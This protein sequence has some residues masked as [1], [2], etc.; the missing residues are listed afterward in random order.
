MFNAIQLF[1][2]RKTTV[3]APKKLYAQT[4][5]VVNHASAFMDPWVIAELQRP[6][7]F[8]LTRGDVFKPLIKPFAWS[9]HMIPIFRTKENGADSS[10]KNE[11][12]FKEV[13]RLLRKRKSILI[14]GEGYTDDIFIRSLKPIKKGPARI[15]FGAM[16]T[17]NW[18]MD[19]KIQCSGINYADPNEF[20]SEVLVA[21]SEPILVK[22]YQKDYIENPSLAINE[23]TKEISSKLQDQLTYLENA[24]LTPFHNQIQSLTK[25][26]IAHQNS[27]TRVALKTRWE[28][29]KK[30][31][32]FLNKH[33]NENE[34]DWKNLKQ[35]H[36]NYSDLLVKEDMKDNWIKKYNDTN[37]VHDWYS[38]PL[39]II[40]LPLF[41]LGTIQHILPYLFVK[42]FT[43]KTFKRAVF[44]SG[45]KMLLGYVVFAL[46][47]IALV[48]TINHYLALDIKKWIL[49]LYIIFISPIMGVIA[50]QYVLLIRN[51]FNRFNLNPSQLENLRVIRNK[52]VNL[53]N[54]KIKL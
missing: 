54:E 40:G 28:Y 26:G 8:F 17:T 1:Y 7:V 23:L 4:I 52:V 36:Q 48:F 15:A 20:R 45:I 50:Y 5:F 27:D 22:N 12:V 6:I 21:N 9:A 31:A 13:Y 38:I 41:L 33:Y 18:E 3:N 24:D 34:E 37:S 35:S 11:V 32:T 49:W 47:A 42:K 51:T 10:K 39:L 53:T 19:L 44:W 14:F 30:L 43:E 16:E 2:K 25:K 29:S 46:F